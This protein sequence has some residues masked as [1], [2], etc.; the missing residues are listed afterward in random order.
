MNVGSRLVLM[1]AML[2]LVLAA[3]SGART[4]YEAIAADELVALG[5]VEDLQ[6]RFNGDAGT[7]RL[8]LLVSPT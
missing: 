7:P 3:C 1:L 8:I 4:T 5:V 2:S 6:T